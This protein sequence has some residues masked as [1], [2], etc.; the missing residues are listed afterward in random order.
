MGGS[1]DL[2]LL[3]VQRR[4]QFVQCFKS[5]MVCQGDDGSRGEL[6]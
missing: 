3:F 1:S 6:R 5:M 4:F 2:S